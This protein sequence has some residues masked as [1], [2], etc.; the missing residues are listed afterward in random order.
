MSDRL[1]NGQAAYLNV[2]TMLSHSLTT[3]TCLADIFHLRRLPSITASVLVSF[4][5]S[6]YAAH[7]WITH[8]QLGG[9][10]DEHLAQMMDC[11]SSLEDS[12]L[13]S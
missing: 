8:M 2:S 4:P 7:H 6:T 10:E 12:A 5:L 13:A 11:I 9:G 1:K 3:K